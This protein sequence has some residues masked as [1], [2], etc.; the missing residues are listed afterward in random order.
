MFLLDTVVLSELRKKS[1]DANLERW[2]AGRH[3]ADLYLSA[4]TIGEIERGIALQEKKDPAFARTLA[5]WVDRVLSLYADRILAADT[6]VCRRWGRLSASLGHAGADLM[7]AA[8]AQEHGL[9]VATRNI[10][11]NHPTG[12]AVVDPFG[13]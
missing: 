3:T 4:V 6:N 8:T 10:R 2:I 9:T 12:V 13:D 11:H 5:S 1:R 7:I